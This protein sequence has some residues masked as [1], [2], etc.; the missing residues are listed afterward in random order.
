M[1]N[2]R[3]GTCEERIG[4][5]LAYAIKCVDE[6][7]A[8]EEAHEEYLEGLLEVSIQPIKVRVGLSW[9]GPADGF[10]IYVDPVDGEIVDVEYYYAD[11]FDGATRKLLDESK[12]KV[13]DLL[14]YYVQS[15]VAHME[16]F[17]V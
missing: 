13:I 11:W 1:K 5:Q 9:G 4:G 7:L 10:Y 15:T 8:D 2:R 12:D 17:P 6:A 3:N 14:G 16:R